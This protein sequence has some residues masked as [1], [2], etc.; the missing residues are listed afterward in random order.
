MNWVPMNDTAN[1]I[2]EDFLASPADLV[3][4]LAHL[5]GP[6]GRRRDHRLVEAALFKLLGNIHTTG[7]PPPAAPVVPLRAPAP[8]PQR[9]GAHNAART[10]GRRFPAEARDGLSQP[11]RRQ[12]CN[13]GQCKWCLD[14]IRWD[15]I[16]NEKFADPSYYG[17]IAVKHNSTLAEA[18]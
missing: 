6:L 8:A 2:P 5:A 10:S 12:Y 1:F 3:G 4:V 13:C 14:N 17:H 11:H 18:L 15:R 9:T 16:F 7:Q